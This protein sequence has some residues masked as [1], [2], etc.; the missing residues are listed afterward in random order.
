MGVFFVNG[1]ISPFTIITCSSKTLESNWADEFKHDKEN[2]VNNAIN[3]SLFM[4]I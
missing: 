2:I 1:D 3:F 4:I